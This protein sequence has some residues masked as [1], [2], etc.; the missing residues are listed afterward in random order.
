MASIKAINNKNGLS[1]KITVCNG[2]NRQ[3]K[4]I[5]ETKTFRPNPNQ[6]ARQQE[7]EL[8]KF[9]YDFE[10]KV[11]NGKCSKGEKVFFETFVFE[12]LEELK[13]RVANSTYDSYCMHLK[14]TIIPF[15]KDYKLYEINT[16]IIERFYA[17]MINKYAHA[18]IIKCKNILNGI[19]K[20]AVSWNILET[21]P[22][23]NSTIPRSKKKQDSGI[24]FFTGVQSLSFLKSLDITFEKTCKG[25]NRNASR[26]SYYVEDY[27]IKMT[28][29]LQLKVF[30]SIAL[31]CGLRRSEILALHWNDI[32]IENRTIKITKSVEKRKECIEYKEPKTKSSVR[33][34]VIPTEIIPLIKKYRSEYNELKLSLGD[35]WKGTGNIFIQAD[36]K[37]MGMSTPYQHFKSHTRRFNNWVEENK[38]LAE[39]QGLERLPDIPLHGLRHSCA[40]LLNHL[41]VSYGEISKVLGHANVSTTLNIY[42]HTFDECTR[43]ASDK[44][45]EFLV[46]N[47]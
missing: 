47:A 41:G 9:A 23:T 22:C 30:F 16:R 13:I 36:G 3:G 31:C 37:L 32:D 34:V 19:F 25:H 21:N 42:T 29:P 7:K 15:F 5:V 17:S 26:E 46:A 12:W 4:K 18:T 40:S 14:N 28:V 1:Y 44:L 24:K 11:K 27:I 43:V 10:E 45:N 20:K 33:T 8:K 6:S 39:K 35:A 38:E 2:T